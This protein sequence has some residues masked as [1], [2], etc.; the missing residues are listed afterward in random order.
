MKYKNTAFIFTKVELY[1]LKD[2]LATQKRDLF[3]NNVLKSG[4]F[5]FLIFFRFHF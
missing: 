5:I 1:G 4:I 2:G 3:L